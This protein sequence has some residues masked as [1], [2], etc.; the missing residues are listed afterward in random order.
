MNEVIIGIRKPNPRWSRVY[1][2]YTVCSH[3]GTLKRPSFISES[4]AKDQGYELCNK[5][6]ELSKKISEIKRGLNQTE[7]RV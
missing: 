5:C 2:T 3:V 4:K 7:G 6:L 1:H